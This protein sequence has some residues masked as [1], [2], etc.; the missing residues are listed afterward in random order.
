MLSALKH[1]SL[2]HTSRT[3]SR[4]IYAILILWKS[5]KQTMVHC[6][7]FCFLS[8]NLAIIRGQ[9]GVR[10]LPVKDRYGILHSGDS[11]AIM[12]IWLNTSFVRTLGYLLGP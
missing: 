12:R 9:E 2:S 5:V 3:V 8:S 7:P 6:S 4:D 10:F 1:Y 11:V